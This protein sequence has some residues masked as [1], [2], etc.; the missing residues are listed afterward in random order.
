[1]EFTKYPT[2]TF[3]ELVIGAGVLLTDFT[4][5][6]ATVTNADILGPTS[7]GVNFTATPSYKDFGEDIDNVPKNTKELKRIDD[8]EVKMSGTFIAITPATARYLAAAADLDS[9]TGKITPRRDL[10][11]TAATGDFRDIWLVADY[12]D[13]NA[14]G[15]SPSTAKAGFVAI[16]MMNALSTGGFQIQTEDKEKGKF[17]FEFTGHYSADA[18]DTPPFEIYIKAGTA[19]T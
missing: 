8:W 10:D 6:N 3:K 13:K 15:T 9:S 18:G 7:G 16:K 12:S 14:T 1:M 4:P 5:A 19:S 2:D 17:A 11:L